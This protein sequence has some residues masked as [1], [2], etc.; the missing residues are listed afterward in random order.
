M[1]RQVNERAE[2][3]GLVGDG[4]DRLEESSGSW[5]DEAGKFVQKQKRGLMLGGEFYLFFFEVSWVF[6]A[7]TMFLRLLFFCGVRGVL[8]DLSYHLT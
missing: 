1:S 2:A 8:L 7:A 4:M 5:A 3:L 6:F